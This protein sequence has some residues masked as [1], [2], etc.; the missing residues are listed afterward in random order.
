MSFSSTLIKLGSKSAF[1]AEYFKAVALI[2][3]LEEYSAEFAFVLR[4][5]FD[6]LTGRDMPDWARS[7]S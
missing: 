4:L 3:V 5:S 6:E 7:G 2:R 1:R